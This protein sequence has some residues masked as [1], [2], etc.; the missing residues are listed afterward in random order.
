MCQSHCDV[1][2]IRKETQKWLLFGQDID[3]CLSQQR[4]A[5]CTLEFSLGIMVVIIYCNAA[6]ATGMALAIA[7]DDDAILVTVG[8]VFHSYICI[9]ELN[10]IATRSIVMPQPPF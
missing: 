9:Y 7:S 5:H 1:D 8:S 6:K 10:V 4:E 3:Y 2:W